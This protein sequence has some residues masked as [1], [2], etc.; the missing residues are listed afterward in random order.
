MQ[1]KLLY[2]HSENTTFPVKLKQL[3]Q[4]SGL[5]ER[6]RDERITEMCTVTIVKFHDSPILQLPHCSLYQ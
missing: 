6:S 3:N 4:M 5:R 1:L 2:S